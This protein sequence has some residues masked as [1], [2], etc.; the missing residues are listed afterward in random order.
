MVNVN[1][2]TS[3]RII[4]AFQAKRPRHLPVVLTREEVGAVLAQLRGVPRLMVTLLCGAGLRLLECA[5]LR[6]KN[7]DVAINQIIVRER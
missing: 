3:G 1:K 4:V 6:V 5:R 2:D 7:A